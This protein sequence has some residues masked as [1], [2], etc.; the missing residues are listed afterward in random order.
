GNHGRNPL[1]KRSPAKGRARDNFDTLM[2]W[3]LARDFAGDARVEFN[4]SESADTARQ[5][6]G[7]TFLLT[8]GDQA[9]G[10]SGIA[11]ALSPL[12]LL[13]HRK[14]KRQSAVGQPYDV[15]VCGHWHQYIHL[16]G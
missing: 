2:G 15:M 16:A 6:Y 13:S 5:V 11:G 10:G 12:M 8:H 1:N 4:V 3:L 9:R 14:G 7:T